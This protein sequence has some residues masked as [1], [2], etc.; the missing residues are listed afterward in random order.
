M[1]HRLGK[2]Y[3][4]VRGDVRGRHQ[5][6]EGVAR[7]GIANHGLQ[8][9]LAAVGHSHAHGPLPLHEHFRHVGANHH[10]RRLLRSMRGRDGTGDPGGASDGV[11][12]RR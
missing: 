6:L 12:C 5:P 9:K 4:H 1:C 8:S 2:A 11:S 3:Q 10:L 7:A